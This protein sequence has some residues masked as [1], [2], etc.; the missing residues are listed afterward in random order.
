MNQIH[1]Y[2]K[3]L[4][5]KKIIIINLIIIFILVLIYFLFVGKNTNI[6]SSHLT[7]S[8]P[9]V[10]SSLDSNISLSLLKSYNF[11]QENSNDYDLKLTSKDNTRICVKKHL[12]NNE[13]NLSLY[14]IAEKDKLFYVKNFEKSANISNI[15]EFNYSSSKGYTYSFHYLS[16]DKKT[17]YYLQTFWIEYNQNYYS[18][19]IEFPLE[20]LQE[21]SSLINGLI[22]SITIK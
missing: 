22:N 20:N 10:Y 11:I 2:K 14:D 9:K 8:K 6:T 13:A 19:D 3:K 5:Y 16:N 18:I 7:T 17:A 21:K 15:S 1:S 12:V 4:N